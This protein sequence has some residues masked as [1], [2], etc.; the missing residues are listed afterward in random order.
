MNK[1]QI[2]ELKAKPLFS[3]TVEEFMELQESKSQ[4]QPNP[5]PVSEIIGIEEAVLLT[6]YKKSTL[7]RKTSTKTIPFHKRDNKVVFL[8]TELENWMLENR[9]ETIEEKSEKLNQI[10][11][12]RRI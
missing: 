5:I 2:E 3:L 12:N 9:Q 6:G 4:G 11:S 1:Q 7:Y 10:F 8:R